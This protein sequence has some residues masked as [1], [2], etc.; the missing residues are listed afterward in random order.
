MRIILEKKIC[1]IEI[2][3]IFIISQYL[4]PSVLIA[5]FYNIWNEDI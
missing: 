4:E 5:N 1:R 2:A 3:P